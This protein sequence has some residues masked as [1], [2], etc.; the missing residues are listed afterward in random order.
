MS[1]QDSGN[2]SS[3]A[4]AD[5]LMLE[6]HDKR[7]CKPCHDDTEL[8]AML[9]LEGMQAGLS[10][11]TIIHKEAAIRRAFDDFDIDRVA[12]Y[13]AAKV[14]ELMRTEGIVRNRL[15]IQSVIKNAR[16]I[17]KLEDG[18]ESFDEYI[19][20]FT[21]GKQI[22]HHIKSLEDMPARSEL[23]ETVSKDMKK[24]GFSFVGPVI[25]YSYLQGIGVYDD[26]LDGC[27]CK[28]RPV[29]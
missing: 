22:I 1:I 18:Y 10:W 17:R 7:W 15:K 26:H 12:A 11:S 24:R 21:D 2:C 23:S 19:W 6:Y 28:S 25:I 8:F 16:A 27:P 29:V 5:P 13:D 20:H 14:E 4:E 9:T 3:W